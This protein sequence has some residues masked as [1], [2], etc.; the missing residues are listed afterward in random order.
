MFYEQEYKRLGS[1]IV[2]HYVLGILRYTVEFM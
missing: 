2:L 1:W